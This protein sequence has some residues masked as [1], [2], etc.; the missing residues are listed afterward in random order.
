MVKSADNLCIVEG[1]VL[2][3]VA[4]KTGGVSNG[5]AQRDRVFNCTVNR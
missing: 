4:S 5:K 3:S 1:L 2:K